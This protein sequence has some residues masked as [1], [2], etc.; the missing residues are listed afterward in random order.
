M[1]VVTLGKFAEMEETRD[2]D[3]LGDLNT[4]EYPDYVDDPDIYTEQG[5]EESLD[6]EG[7]SSEE[8]GFMR[9]FVFG[10]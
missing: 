10:I 9:G 5:L 4:R 2:I 1:E 6:D 7:I 8:E 3:E